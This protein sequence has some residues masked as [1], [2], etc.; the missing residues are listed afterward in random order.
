MKKCPKIRPTKTFANEN[1]QKPSTRNLSSIREC[2][3]NDLKVKFILQSDDNSDTSDDEE[4]TTE[5]PS[6]PSSAAGPNLAKARKK[7]ER[8]KKK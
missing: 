7:P 2:F 1:C 6:G 3:R 5:G 8:K 4:D